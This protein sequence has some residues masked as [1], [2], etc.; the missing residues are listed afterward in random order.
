MMTNKTLLMLW[1]YLL[2]VPFSVSAQFSSDTP[3]CKV[4]SSTTKVQVSAGVTS[5]LLIHRVQPMYPDSASQSRIE[6]VVVVDATIDECGHVIELKPISGPSELV[7]ATIAAVK[8]WEYKP[9][10]IS[11]RPTAIETRVA[12]KFTLSKH[13]TTPSDWKEYVY[14]EDAFA[15]SLPGDPHPHKSSQMPNGMAYSVP[16]SNGAGFSLYAM[17]A[18]DSCGDAVRSESDK[19]GSDEG[20]SKGF[21]TISVRQ[22]A[23][24]GYTGIEFLQQIP[25]GK[26]DYERWLCSA[27]RL[28]ILTSTWNP[29]EQEP[30]ELRRIVDSF[31]VSGPEQKE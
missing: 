13:G 1:I 15:I 16:L 3:S 12:V 19:A 20:R 2:I 26:I 21:K 29:S 11:G 6:G 31:R 27:N 5:G 17:E 14:T 23:G 8:Q 9:Y 28:Y 7:P 18:T 22:I 25:T 30:K 24:T 10:M 4:T